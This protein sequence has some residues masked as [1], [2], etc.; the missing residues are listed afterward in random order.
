MRINADGTLRFTAI[1]TTSSII[2]DITTD[3]SISASQ[4]TRIAI[5]RNAGLASIFIEGIEQSITG[6]NDTTNYSNDTSALN[7][8][9]MLDVS[10]NPY[11]GYIDEVRIT[12]GQARYTSDYTLDTEEFPTQQC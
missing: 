6:T 5:V 7:I 12:V 8:G 2:T 1:S 11:V 10:A 3:S 9:S 4:W